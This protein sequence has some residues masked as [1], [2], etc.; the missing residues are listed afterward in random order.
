MLPCHSFLSVVLIATSAFQPSQAE[1]GRLN[2]Y[3]EAKVQSDDITANLAAAATW[4]ADGKVLT[5]RRDLQQ[6]VALNELVANNECNEKSYQIM[7]NNLRATNLLQRME[8]Y[9]VKRR[10]DIIVRSVFLKQAKQCE[11]AYTSQYQLDE[12]LMDENLVK[13]AQVFARNFIDQTLLERNLYDYKQPDSKTLY[14]QFVEPDLTIKTL[15]GH[16][17]CPRRALWEILGDVPQRKYLNLNVDEQTGKKYLDRLKL[18]QLVD[19]H[20]IAPC[21]Y[22]VDQLGPKL[23]NQAK[24]YKTGFK[25]SQKDRKFYFGWSCFNICDLFLRNKSTLTNDLINQIN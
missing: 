20:L 16:Q 17:K 21:R 6:F 3:L 13:K 5:P 14:E 22:F 18:D 11:Q 8:D 4:L 25:V 7:A 12:A 1:Y 19:E 2:K 15:L 9:N 24:L 23:F 10:V